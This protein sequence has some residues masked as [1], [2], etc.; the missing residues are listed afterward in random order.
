MNVQN[1]LIFQGPITDVCVEAE[2]MIASGR[3]HHADIFTA[4]LSFFSLRRYIS[5]IPI[6]LVVLCSFVSY[7]VCVINA[8]TVTFTQILYAELEI[9]R[10][11]KRIT[12]SKILILHSFIWMIKLRSMWSVF[13]S[14]IQLYTH[15]FF[16]FQT[17]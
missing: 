11:Q 6:L 13:E 10:V 8:I 5:F 17:I 12:H 15:D 9:I 4:N 1:N 16:F 14:I 3:T 7:K 2:V